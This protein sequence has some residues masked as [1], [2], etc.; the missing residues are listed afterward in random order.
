MDNCAKRIHMKQWV[1][2][3]SCIYTIKRFLKIVV[4]SAKAVWPFQIVVQN[5]TQILWR[6]LV[7]QLDYSG[8]T[9]LTTVVVR[10]MVQIPENYQE[11]GRWRWMYNMTQKYQIEWYPSKWIKKI[12]HKRESS[13]KR[14]IWTITD[15]WQTLEITVPVRSEDLMDNSHWLFLWLF[16]D[17]LVLETIAAVNICP[18]LKTLKGSSTTLSSFAYHYTS[19][20]YIIM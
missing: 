18:I 5:D 16:S 4:V 12:E 15:R 20:T 17:L 6:K 2:K 13:N 3:A 14:L 11:K 7:S 10:D 19:L 1:A 9:N 8:R